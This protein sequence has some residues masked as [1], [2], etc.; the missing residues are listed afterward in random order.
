MIETYAQVGGCLWS[1]AVRFYEKV[2]LMH[3]HVL[4]IIAIVRLQYDI[5][6]RC[7]CVAL[8]EG[9]FRSK[10]VGGVV[11]QTSRVIRPH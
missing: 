1:V 8:V 11:Q 10:C 3:V 9:T 2:S 5:G 4:A 7:T 6:L